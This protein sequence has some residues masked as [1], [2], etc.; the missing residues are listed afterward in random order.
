MRTLPILCLAAAL[1][2]EPAAAQ[3]D[4]R[5][6]IEKAVK[7]LGGEEVLTRTAASHT[8]LKGTFVGLPGGAAAGIAVTGEVWS[9][10]GSER[11]ALVIELG[12][13]KST[14]TRAWHNGKGWEQNDG[15]VKDM[16][17]DDLAEARQSA[18]V[19]RVL[20]LVP[21]LKDKDFTLKALG[22]SKVDGAEVDGVR[23]SSPGR[24]DVTLYF[25]PVTGF[26]R[27]A[28]YREKSKAAGK[29]VLTATVFEDYRAVEPAA[30]EERALKAA[31]V[32]TDGAALLEFLRGQV[33]DEADREKVKRLVKQ[34]GSD[35]F[36]DREKAS[37]E[38]TRLG[39]AAV[40][41]LRRAAEG[42]DAEV[43]ARARRCLEKIAA[44]TA[45]AGLLPAALA[46]VTV[47]RPAGAAEVL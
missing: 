46:V 23:V 22:R 26:P 8:R 18:H 37:A 13:Q 45:P 47:K 27:R 41:D 44:P 2:P 4:P 35:S 30:A 20:T 10:P 21:L 39:A 43:A 11:L 5:P 32:G 40:A 33:R 29:E 16:G 7:A 14:M 31:K 36:E 12:G 25:D 38:L 34:L 17:A 15:A 9:Q 24:P 42:D 19:D 28:E 3:D 1:V 6:I